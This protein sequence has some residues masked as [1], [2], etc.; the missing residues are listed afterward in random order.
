MTTHATFNRSLMRSAVYTGLL[1]VLFVFL[2]WADNSPADIL[3][4]LPYFIV[5]YFLLFSTGRPEVSDWLREKMKGNI[6]LIFLF[7]VLLVILYFSYITINGGNPLKGTTFLFPYLLF[8]PVL[9]FAAYENK[10]QK[11]G[12]FDFIAFVLFFF[13]VTL[14]AAGPSD[15]PFNGSG[16]DSVYRI[17]V[18]LLAVFAFVTIR[19]IRDV[20][21][22][23]LFKWKYL[24]ITLW[25]WLVFYAF[26]F[27]IG[28]AVHFITLSDQHSIDFISFEK[29]IKRTLRIFLHTALFEEL[30]FRGLLQNML[31][32]RI[33][34]SGSWK[35]SFTWA[36]PI[37]I[38][39]ALVIGYSL[40]G[41]LPW[42]PALVTV[43]LFAAAYGM[44]KRGKTPMGAYTA[45]AITSMLFGMLHAHVGSAIFVGLAAIGGWAYG[46]VYLKTG[47]V[48]YAALLHAL[49][50]VTPLLFGLELAK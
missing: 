14:L 9:L 37:L 22:Y 17:S 21:F 19:N 27:V 23:P 10:T 11:T 42:F 8:F 13:P 34:H 15:L 16:F 25:V 26:A 38:V 40:K 12:W 28:Y 18:M 39:L 1:S 29:I 43:M 45:L 30:V 24:F 47:N 35:L 6:R 46:Y 31:S 20:G 3:T 32:K 49:V 50:N 36:L 5:L 7:P 4:A 41:N 33:A 44:E 2:T 48:F